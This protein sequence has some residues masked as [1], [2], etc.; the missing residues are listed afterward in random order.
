MSGY[1]DKVVYI[2]T[3][4]RLT[5]LV[6]ILPAW[7]K[8]KPDNILLAVEPGEVKKHEKFLRENSIVHSLGTEI[9]VVPVRPEDRGIGYTRNFMVKHARN[10]GFEA[11]VMADDDSMPNP[12]TNV[13]KL[14]KR[15]ESTPT[16][17]LGACFSF[18]GLMLGNKRIRETSRPYLVPGG[19]GY[20]MF[21]L[22]L[23]LL[24]ELDINFDKRLHTFW[25]DAELVRD[26]MEAGGLAWH[27]HTGVKATS[28]GKRYERGGLSAANNES[29]KKRSRRERECRQIVYDKWGSKYI[30][31][32]DKRPRCAWQKMLDDFV[33][34]WRAKAVWL[35]DNKE[36]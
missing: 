8:Q 16:I 36:S 22:N 12:D 21:S 28:I 5:N 1:D 13:W 19:M 35:K 31:H 26:G 2:P 18:Y 9:N 34:G 6:R 15:L 7:D 17:G 11:I 4:N 33:E 29:R 25:E 30:S 24:E 3:R 10:M 27:V 20:I 23:P 32:P 14:V